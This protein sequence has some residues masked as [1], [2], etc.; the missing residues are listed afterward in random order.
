LPSNKRSAIL[1]L[2]IQLREFQNGFSIRKRVSHP[3]HHAVH[4]ERKKASSAINNEHAKKLP[5]IQVEN[6]SIKESHKTIAPRNSIA[7]FLNNYKKE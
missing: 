5:K 6:I 3:C 2:R 7:Y 4:T 1:R